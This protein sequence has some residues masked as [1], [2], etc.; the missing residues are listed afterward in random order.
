VTPALVVVL[1]LTLSAALSGVGLRRYPQGASPPNWFLL[2]W[3][4]SAILSV[5]SLCV[6][7]GTELIEL[8]TLP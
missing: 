8:V 3:A 7:L 4:L 2:A 1:A 6:L 5:V